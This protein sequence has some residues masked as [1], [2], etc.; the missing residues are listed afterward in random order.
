MFFQ[1]ANYLGDA[2][3]NEEYA[4]LNNNKNMLMLTFLLRNPPLARRI[5]LST[6][7]ASS[8]LI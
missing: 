5:G 7:N 3:D 8:I 4:I 2:K 1:V 6:F